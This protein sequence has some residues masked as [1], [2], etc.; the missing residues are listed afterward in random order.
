L[1]QR[2]WAQPASSDANIQFYSNA[3]QSH[4]DY[5]DAQ[6]ALTVTF[7]TEFLRASDR[8]DEVKPLLIEWQD[9]RTAQLGLLRGTLREVDY[10]SS[11]YTWC[12]G[13]EKHLETPGFRS[14]LQIR[15]ARLLPD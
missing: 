9:R 13:V 6:Q 8:S 4:W 15:M 11:L 12:G 5:F 3:V 7:H 14:Q 2:A 1:Q 10:F